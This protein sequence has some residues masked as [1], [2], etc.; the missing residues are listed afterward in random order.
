MGVKAKEG[1]G[2]EN[3]ERFDFELIQYKHEN[4]YASYPFLVKDEGMG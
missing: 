2:V 3:A 4:G 1:H